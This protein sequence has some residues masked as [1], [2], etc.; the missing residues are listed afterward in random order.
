MM[1]H[2]SVGN[3]VRFFGRDFPGLVLLLVLL[4]P[5]KIQRATE[6]NS[7]WVDEVYSLMLSGRSA[8]DIISLSAR[9]AHPPFYYLLLKLWIWA[10]KFPGFA[11]SLWWARSLNIFLWIV[12]SGAVW[13]SLRSLLGR[14]EGTL[15]SWII[16]SSSQIAQ[17]TKEIRG[18]AAACFGLF[19][20]FLLLFLLWRKACQEDHDHPPSS[21]HRRIGDYLYWVIYALSGLV[22][23][24]SHL[25]AS[26]VLL[27]LGIIWVLLLILKRPKKKSFFYGGAAAQA[28]ILLCFF[29]WF[30]RIKGQIMF[31]QQWIHPWMTIPTGWNLIKVFIVWLPYGWLLHPPGYLGSVPYIIGALSLIIPLAACLCAKKL[32]GEKDGENQL[33][34]LMIFASWGI[35]VFFI[36]TLFTLHRFRGLQVFHGPRYPAL[37]APFWITG[38]VLLSLFAAR[39]LKRSW[40]YSLFLL[41]PLF[42]CT[43][44]GQR[45][46]T[47]VEATRGLEYWRIR[48]RK[49]FPKPG[50]D[51]YVMP[52]N[53]IPYFKKG[54]KNFKVHPIEEIAAVP[55]EQKDV[56][57][58][59]ANQCVI[60][61][62]PKDLAI[63]HNIKARKFS[64]DLDFL[65]IPPFTSDFQTYHLIDFN[66]SAAKYLI[67]VSL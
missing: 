11:P 56:F 61:Y 27:Y 9:D 57:I 59:D 2:N 64:R 4:L 62:S 46:M 33:R 48:A 19:T 47:L 17:V 15:A 14:T 29:P 54:L 1:I 51:L 39:R 7:L 20:C 58:F 32:S 28:F 44:L 25:L 67:G 36:M 43:F 63:L 5:F 50:E 60:L 3:F 52:S 21:F 66:H 35:A 24:Y 8:P 45:I 10:G 38:L 26:F 53:L 6:Q 42:Y 41:I 31:L 40:K 23:L 12:F 13:F 30:F 65:D 49:Y 55:R 37:V 18:Y 22:S 34:R 16:L